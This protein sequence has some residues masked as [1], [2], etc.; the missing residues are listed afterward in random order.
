MDQHF[1]E[2]FDSQL[3]L[4][5]YS[6]ELGRLKRLLSYVF[7]E[8]SR[9]AAGNAEI[10]VMCLLR[11]CKDIVDETLLLVRGGFSR[12]AVGGLRT[13][14]ECVVSARYISLHPDKAVNFLNV[15]N[16]QWAKIMQNIPPEYRPVSMESKLTEDVPKYGDKK[17]I[18]SKDIQWSDTHVRQMAQEAGAVIHLHPWAFDQ[19]SAYIHPSAMFVARMLRSNPETHLL[20]IRDR[21]PVD[22]KFAIRFVHDLALNAIDLRL[23]TASDPSASLALQECLVDFKNIWGYDAHI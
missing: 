20:E 4:N 18:T 17:P 14:Y 13:M 19:A 3:S 11:S 15:L 10:V 12:A 6:N 5:K 8:G 7:V 9:G 16:P 21:S 22:E 23:K 1:D 2:E